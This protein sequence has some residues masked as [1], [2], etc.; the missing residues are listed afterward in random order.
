MERL[1]RPAAL[2]GTLRR[3]RS[4]REHG[5]IEPPCVLASHSPITPGSPNV[6]VWRASNTRFYWSGCQCRRLSAK[7]WPL[8][9]L[10]VTQA[11]DVR[12]VN[13]PSCQAFP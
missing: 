8:G 13:G 12:Q 3:P 11:T 1:C 6:I 2:G 5:V 9:F 4:A 10:H 7:P